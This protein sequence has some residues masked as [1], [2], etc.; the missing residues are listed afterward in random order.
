[1]KIKVTGTHHLADTTLL[2]HKGFIDIRDNGTIYHLY[3]ALGVP[4]IRRITVLATVNYKLVGL[5]HRL[6]DGDTV[7]FFP[8]L[9]SG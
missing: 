7:S 5:N 4:A 3:K 2:D 1:M 6:Q 9:K 8:V